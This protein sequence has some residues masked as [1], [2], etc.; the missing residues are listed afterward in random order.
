MTVQLP[1]ITKE[2]PFQWLADFHAAMAD[3]DQQIAALPSVQQVR[4]MRDA[5]N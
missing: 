4:E 2:N 1:V 5:T 3:I